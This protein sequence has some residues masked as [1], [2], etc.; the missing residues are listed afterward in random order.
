[1]SAG[2]NSNVRLGQRVFHV[3]TEDRGPA[4]S[5]IDTAVYFE[6]RVV[7]VQSTPYPQGGGEAVSETERRKFVEA[8]HRGIVDS[9]RAGALELDENALKNAARHKKHGVTVTLLNSTSWMSGGHAD[10]KIAVRDHKRDDTPVASA[11]IEAGFEGTTPVESHSAT[12]DA[13]G[14]A[15]MRFSLPAGGV[16]G[17]TLVIRAIAPAGEDEIRFH[18][19][20]KSK[21]TAAKK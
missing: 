6:G 11:R 16:A 3:Q 19:K 5:K 14:H 2:F 8:Q 15:G 20:P 21:V 18:L 12:T 1:M 17:T 7:H 13:Q 9:L 4:H 10:L